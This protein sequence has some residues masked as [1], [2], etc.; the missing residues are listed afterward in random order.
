MGSTG[1][2]GYKAKNN[3]TL[4]N[5]TFGIPGAVHFTGKVPENSGLDKP[6]GNK[7]TLKVPTDDKTNILFQFKL[8]K[9]D[10]LMTI[11]A[12]RNGVPEVKCKVAVD[13]GNPSLDQLI[14]SGSRGE[15]LNAIKMKDLMQKSTEVKESQ[16]GSIADT[17]LKKKQMNKK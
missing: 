17:L 3:G 12:Y 13:S 4:T 1:H 6:G 10:K 14:K 16:L 11:T 5:E 8:S 7:I 15:R 2:G 9:N